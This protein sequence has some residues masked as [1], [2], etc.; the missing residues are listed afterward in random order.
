MNNLSP[1]K[2]ALLDVMFKRSRIKGYL[3]VVQAFIANGITHIYTVTGIPVYELQAA[4]AEAG[5]RVTGTRHQQAAVLMAT[6]HNDVAGSINAVVIVSASPAVTNVATGLLVASDN[7]WPIIVL[8]GRRRGIIGGQDGFQELDAAELHESIT[9]WAHC[10]IE[11]SDIPSTINQAF[12]VVGEG[13]PGPVYLDITEDALYMQCISSTVMP[14]GNQ[15]AKILIKQDEIE[16]AAALLHNSK[17]PA[18]I[19]GKGTRWSLAPDGHA[20]LIEQH[21]I[22]FISSPM[23]RGI[24]SDEH[25]LCF[26]RAKQQLQATADVVL[27]LGARLNWAFRFGNQINPRVKAIQVDIDP[28]EAKKTKKSAWALLRMLVTLSPT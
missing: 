17:Q 11:T 8:G 16:R 13:R 27:I 1:N 7:A 22:A 24:L 2:R 26:N 12:E 6:A 18:F 15:R 28:D 14:P 4:A 9:K 21:Q 3:L 20:G 10:V 23:G 5:I 19:L 25:P